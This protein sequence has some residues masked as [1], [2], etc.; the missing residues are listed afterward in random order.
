MRISTYALAMTIVVLVLFAVCCT[1]LCQR[2]IALRSLDHCKSEV[3]RLEDVRQFLATT[4]RLRARDI[5]E[6]EAK[7]LAL[8]EQVVELKTAWEESDALLYKE[9][10]A[11]L[12]GRINKITSA[13]HVREMQLLAEIEHLK[14]ELHLCKFGLP[15]SPNK[16]PNKIP[17]WDALEPTCQ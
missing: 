1:T 7:N 12:E 10:N 9:L 5:E 17:N 8:A 16:I 15:P 14:G 6:W 13:F 2:D 3:Q 11:V 4:C